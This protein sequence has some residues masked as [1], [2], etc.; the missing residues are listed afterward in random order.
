M[1]A[2][3]VGVGQ[4]LAGLRVLSLAQ[5]FPGPFACRLLADLGA[6]VV[7]VEQIDGG[8]PARTLPPLFDAL[9]HGQRSLAVDLKSAAGLDVFARLAA[10]SRVVLE[11]FRPGVA[12][13]L[14]VGLEDVRAIR[15]D[16]IYCSISGFGQECDEPGHDLG[17][18]ARAGVIAPKTF[19]PAEPG[20]PLADLAA[21][22]YA[23]LGV[24]AAVPERDSVFLDIS[25]TDA[26][27]AWSAPLLALRWSQPAGRDATPPGYGLFRTRDGWACI[28]IFHH[29]DGFWAALCSELGLDD[30]AGMPAAE[31][32]AGAEVLRSRIADRVAGREAGELLEALRARGVPSGPVNDAEAVRVDPLLRDRGTVVAAADRTVVRSPFAR[33][34]AV[35]RSA[36]PRLGEDTLSLLS[37]LSYSPQEID[38]LLA[39]RV[40][41]VD[42]SESDRLKEVSDGTAEGKHP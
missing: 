17:F 5:Q 31:R 27:V 4:P 3:K 33:L 1:P 41:R 15:P 39:E 28:A 24:V 38:C 23:A 21:A 26:L 42:G 32:V 12:A 36:A 25:M 30:I 40:I 11:G 16:V 18:Q 10:T 37:E 9:N 22:M 2:G 7:L 35:D 13:R 29:E 6:E 34:H 20:L 19:S 14:G 8:D